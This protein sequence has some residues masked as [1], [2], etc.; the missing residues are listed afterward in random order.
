MSRKRYG[1]F[2]V[3]VE[4][5]VRTQD[6]VYEDAGATWADGHILGNG[7]MA[8]IAYAP[9]ALEWTINKVDVFDGRNAPK[10]RLTYKQVMAE[11][12]KR[13][14]KNLRF[15]QDLEKPDVSKA[16]LQSLLKSCGQ[17][18]V[19]TGRTEYSWGAA[20][21]Y[22]IRQVL[23]LWDATDYMDMSLPMYQPSG[24]A[25]A[26]KCPPTRVR[27]FMSR[28][29]NLM[30]A[31]MTDASGQ[32]LE[33]KRIELCRPFDG[34]LEDAEFGSKGNMAWFSQKMA[35]GSSYAMVI[36]ATALDSRFCRKAGMKPLAKGLDQP[37]AEN[38]QITSGPVVKSDRVSLTVTGDCD[39]FVATA[40]SYES[41]N[42]LKMAKKI[43]AAGMSKGANKLEK[44]HAKWWANF[45]KKS[46][47][48]FDPDAMMEQLW[49][50]GLYQV[51]SALGHTPIPGLMGLW[52]GHHDQNRQCCF[53]AAYTL[54]QNVQNHTLP[55]FCVNH[56]E[57]AVPFMDTFL[58]GQK[59]TMKE[60]REWFEMPGACYGLE[61]MFMGGEPSF[62]SDY[63]MSLCG[64]P[65]AGMIYVWAYRY[66]RDKQLLKDKIYPYLREICRFWAAFMEKDDNGIYHIPPTVPAEIGSLSR[67]A[68]CPLSLLKPCL[69]IAVEASTL[70]D[71]DAEDR[72]KW[73]DLLA[74]YPPYPTKK[75]IIVDGTDIPLDHQSHETFRL[76][77]IVLAHDDRQETWKLV[78]TTLEHLHPTDTAGWHWFFCI[79]TMLMYG[80]K[81][82]M[83]PMMNMELYHQLKPNGLFVHCGIG[84][85]R[86][87]HSRTRE[88][89][90]PTPENNSAFMMMVTEMLM[91]S[92][93]GIVRLFPGMTGKA[94]ARF[95][96]LLAEGSFLISSEMADGKVRFVS[97]TAQRSDTV[98]VKNPWRGKTVNVA[99][100]N[101][102][103]EKIK[104]VTLS[105][106]LRKGESVTLTPVGSRV[107]V[108]KIVSKRKACPKVKVFKDGTF[109]QLGKGK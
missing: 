75:G 54:D 66:T 104:G 84:S 38:P 25:K 87:L 81:E 80:M 79:R 100:K 74:N 93:N 14:A 67:D 31:R 49:Y 42:P 88:L 21:P 32:M 11:A 57:L 18:K 37:S 97:I 46:F 63:R 23:S 70:F 40:T 6:L 108:K 91:Q 36:A 44:E 83:L 29:S 43:V 82:E 39:L 65:F 27:S 92:F 59:R 8:A 55:V 22:K 76:H 7:D 4:S 98:Q 16:P 45:W 62:G 2:D 34:D 77:P 101:G 56:P 64:G 68:I 58:N 9:F 50:F 106:S 102:K 51:G 78:K 3:D 94:N 33:N 72:E 95:G 15:L 28:E 52:H 1:M 35:D 24:F 105:I 89:I 41:S 71:V 30:V 85:D 48:Q 99:R 109:A 103:K 69:E 107:S 20:Q 86:S 53:W 90:T 26:Y 73:Q 17:V 10:K 61:M 19:R 47:V 5:I 60:T 96:D 13:G 12:K